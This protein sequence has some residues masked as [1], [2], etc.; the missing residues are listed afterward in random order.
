M[1]KLLYLDC[2]IYTGYYSKVKKYQEAELKLISI[3]VTEPMGIKVDGKIPELA[4]NRELFSR[5]KMGNIDEMEYTSI[6]MDQL[7][8]I[9]I[10]DILLKIHNFGDDVVLLCWEA[11]NR[12]CHRHILADYING[13]TK[14]EIKEYE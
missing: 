13:K 3:S 9:G 8:K 12:F 5:Y 2:M 4:P 11:P 1:E 14:L 7:D 6:Y 10:R